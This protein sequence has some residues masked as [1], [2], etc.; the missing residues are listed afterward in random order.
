MDTVLNL[1]DLAKHFSDEDKA[2]ELLE[3]M[4]WG[5][6]GA[7]CPRCGGADPYKLTPKATSEKPGRKGLYKCRACRKQFT[8]TVGTIFEDSHIPLSKWMLAIHLIAAS[9]KGMS[10]HQLHR[11]LGITYKSAWFMAHRLRYCM[12]QEP[13]AS[14]LK[15][16]VEADETY[17][18]GRRKTGKKGFSRNGKTPVVALVECGGRVRAMVMPKVQAHEIKAHILAN[19][20]QDVRLMTDESP[21][22]NEVG[23]E[24]ASHETVKHSIKEYARGDVHTNTV[25]GFFSLLK[26][27][28]TGIYHHVGT[29]HVHRYVDEFAFRYDTRKMTDA[30]R[31]ELT[32]QG[33][34]GKRLTYKQPTGTGAN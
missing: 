22:Y 16:I 31:A 25:E 24:L 6:S 18:G 26:R 3:E 2:R 12:T 33:A 5:Q 13:I 4:R 29:G 15:G 23:K 27:G 30:E 28:I 7:V 17:I 11:M 8:A 14:K 9:K 10:A 32:V 34:E 21:L 20:E 19:V 1:S